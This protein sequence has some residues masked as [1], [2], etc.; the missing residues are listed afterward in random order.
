[1]L[2]KMTISLVASYT[3]LNLDPKQKYKF[4]HDRL[5]CMGCVIACSELCLAKYAARNVS[6]AELS[7]PMN[8]YISS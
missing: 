8:F 6:K 4:W 5:M 2:F 7:E 3:L 1:V